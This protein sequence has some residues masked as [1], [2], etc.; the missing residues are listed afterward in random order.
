MAHK[1]HFE[2][3]LDLIE[4]EREAEK[5]ENK[6]ELEK[7]PLHV[8]EA[9]GKTVT[10]LQFEGDDQGVG[11]LPLLILSK[12]QSAASGGLSPFHSMNQGD[13][14]RL[15]YPPGS[16]VNPVDGTLYEVDEFHVTVAL[17]GHP[18][19]PIP[20]GAYQLDLL[21][22]DATYKRMR[23]AIKQMMR[24]GKPDLIRLRKIFLEIEA[25]KVE[26]KPKL[27]IFDKKLNP[28]QVDAVSMCF[29]T[30]DVALVHGPP[31]TGKTTVLI[32]VIRQATAQGLRVLASAPSNIAVDNI[33]EKLIPARIRMVRLGHP[34][35]VMEDL[36]HVTLAA[37]QEEHEGQEEVRKMDEERHRLM[38][39]FKRRDR[40]GLG[41][42]TREKIEM[43]KQIEA[44]WK[45]ARNQE[46]AVR[47][48][49]I[50][51][52][53][54]VLA[55]HG[56]IGRPLSKEKFDLVVLDE[57]SQKNRKAER[58]SERLGFNG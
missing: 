22:S 27:S 7:F 15:S 6:R 52:S 10:K 41:L 46:F 44:L 1:K 23:Q 51:S 19:N 5:E 9:L 4:I 35:R 29:R 24:T 55:T 31:G 26:K 42:G 54:V 33:V 18:P 48:Q 39:R 20:R 53:Q 37:Q 3:L 49:I 43:E 40:R 45:D 47:R 56:G 8:R 25:P 30:P 38:T 34:A 2:T 16:K 36:H 57:A 58:I 21:G 17:S 13:N 32:E 28:Y 50:Q 11:G 12:A 14:V